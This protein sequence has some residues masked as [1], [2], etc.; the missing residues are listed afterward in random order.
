M[1]SHIPEHRARTGLLSSAS[2]VAMA[3]EPSEAALPPQEP[4]S[5]EEQRIYDSFVEGIYRTVFKDKNRIRPL[6]AS[7]VDEEGDP[8]S[9]LATAAAGIV[10]AAG[11]S[12]KAK[13]RPVPTEIQFAALEE[14]T[15]SL[16]DFVE[17][18]TGREIFPQ[19][20]LDGAFLQA[21]STLGDMLV[22]SGDLSREEAQR[23]LQELAQKDREGRLAEEDP[24]LVAAAKFYNEIGIRPPGQRPPQTQ[25]V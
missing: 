24:E 14:I 25:E 1:P 9:D 7:I 22:Q 13:R 8:K 5:P 4:A 18:V 12:A 20:V 23:D 19:E 11:Q 17:K 10:H 21:A 16:A 3:A 2:P 6:V 15:E